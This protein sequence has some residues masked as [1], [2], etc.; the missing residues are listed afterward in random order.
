MQTDAPPCDRENF[1]QIE[2]QDPTIAAVHLA[3]ACLWLSTFSIARSAE[4]LTFMILIVVAV[5]RLP[6]TRRLYGQIMRTV[7]F[8]A[9]LAF[10][11][12]QSLSVLWSEAPKL[13]INDIAARQVFACLALWPLMARWRV[14]LGAFIAGALAFSVLVITLRLWSTEFTKYI[15]EAIVQKDIGPSGLTFAVALAALT[16][17]WRSS[18][19]RAWFAFLPAAVL[20]ICGIV[21]LGQ[22]MPFLAGT[23][24]ALLS[25]VA[26]IH[27][28]RINKAFIW[29]IVAVIVATA[30]AGTIVFVTT[31]NHRRWIPSVI[32]YVTDETT[33]ISPEDAAE[34]TSHRGPL[35]K[36]AI[37]I[38]KDHPLIGSGA[39]GFGIENKSRIIAD[40]NLY[41]GS[42]RLR[43]FFSNRNSSHNALLDEASQRGI[44]GAALFL[45]VLIS[46]GW[47]AWRVDPS[48]ATLGMLAVWIALSLTTP[49]TAR[50]IPLLILALIVT[51][52]SFIAINRR[53][54]P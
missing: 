47:W 10:S 16:G 21:T 23:G 48:N 4:G 37:A 30:I 13:G 6:R 41:G 17:Q 38:W 44:I 54:L 46:C 26:P 9:F 20:L 28:R 5:L 45:T 25:V 36:M 14:L 2:R 43:T 8:I 1:L 52:C 32:S 51:R 39:S 35:A 24:S 49:A 11:L 19:A 50:G 42:T 18:M 53:W 31:G 7:P 15:N 34:L 40:P 3:A 33:D 12:W 22:R 27:P 29:R